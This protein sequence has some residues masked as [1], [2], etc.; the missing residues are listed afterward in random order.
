MHVLV[1]VNVCVYAYVTESEMVGGEGG[2]CVCWM[3]I[4]L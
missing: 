1:C 3:G 4:H 2:E